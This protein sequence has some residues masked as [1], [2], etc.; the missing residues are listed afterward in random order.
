MFRVIITLFLFMGIF[1]NAEEANKED[2][3]TFR[4]LKVVYEDAVNNNKM[5]TLK[6]YLH[7]DFSFV[8]LTNRHFND[9]ESFHKQWQITRE[10][11]LKG[12]TYNITLK[13]DYSQIVGDT[14]ITK[15]T[16]TS[17]LVTGDS[18]TFEFSES[19]T[20]V[21]VKEDG[22]WKVIRIHSSI[23]PFKNP[24]IVSEVK[25]RITKYCIISLLVG[26]IAGFLLKIL[27]S[28]KKQTE[29]V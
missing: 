24:F 27:L 12:G 4:K 9:F 7:K 26:L 29:N 3:D 5:E 14:A 13:P 15:G 23:D 10:K 2:H 28:K 19:W 17:V 8:T 22:Q 6:P 20:A 16:S 25:K 21:C 1:A 11:L 18:E